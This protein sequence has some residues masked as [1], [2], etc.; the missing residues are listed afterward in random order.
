MR[1]EA[2]A[3]GFATASLG[4]DADSPTG[5]HGLYQR[6]GFVVRDTWVVQMKPIAAAP[7]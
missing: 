7:R 3:A 1:S 6:A 4:A 2:R 5:A